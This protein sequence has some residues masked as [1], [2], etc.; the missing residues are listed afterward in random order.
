MTF[1]NWKTV[2]RQILPLKV[3]NKSLV[4]KVSAQKFYS[5]NISQNANTVS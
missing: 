2:K 1:K 3:F 5:T 4:E